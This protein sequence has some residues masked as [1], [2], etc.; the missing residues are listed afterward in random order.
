MYDARVFAI[1]YNVVVVV[2]QY[3]L[4]ALGFLSFED[5]LVSGN[6]GFQDQ[7]LALTWIQENIAQF[8]GDPSQVTLFGESAGSY[9]VNYHIISHH[10]KGFQAGNYAKWCFGLLSDGGI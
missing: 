1:R 5:D 4:G 9:S 2:L 3:R 8:G 10:S 7:T 6:L